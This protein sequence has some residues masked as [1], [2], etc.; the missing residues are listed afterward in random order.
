MASSIYCSELDFVMLCLVFFNYFI[1]VIAW[2]T[3]LWELPLVK[4]NNKNRGRKEGIKV[5]Q[6]YDIKQ[7]ALPC[8]RLSFAPGEE[9][10]H[11]PLALSLC[12]VKTP[13]LLAGVAVLCSHDLALCPLFPQSH[14]LQWCWLG[15]AWC[16]IVDSRWFKLSHSPPCVFWCLA[17]CAICGPFIWIPFNTAN[18]I[19][20]VVY[21]SA[22]FCKVLGNSTSF[23]FPCF[24]LT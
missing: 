2:L 11:L 23:L 5:E 14:L 20:Q 7:E 15:V 18:L 13:G 21:M 19:P 24:L 17:A 22:L 9:A 1:L 4:K 6:A 12:R 16:I 3:L 8:R 10:A